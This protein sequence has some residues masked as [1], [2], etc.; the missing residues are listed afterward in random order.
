MI[1]GSHQLA[2]LHQSVTIV[3]SRMERPPCTA[4]ILG[5]G[6]GDVTQD[7]DSPVA[8]DYA[9]LPG[10]AKT[11]AGGH[12][13]QLVCGRLHGVEVVAMSGRF[14]RYEGYSDAEITFPVRL[15]AALGAKRLVVSNAAGGLNPM[16]NTGDVVV[17]QDHIDL[18]RRS[19]GAGVDRTAVTGTADL[20]DR[21]LIA[22]ALRAAR[23]ADFHAQRGVYLA[24]LGPTYETRAEYRMMRSLGA[25]VVGMSTAPEVCV[26]RHLGMRVLALSIVSNVAQPDQPQPTHH[27]EVLAAGRAATSKLQAIVAAVLH[28]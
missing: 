20:Y 11:T 17:I 16:L 21:E 28:E 19:A 2:A 22:G 3:R 18:G 7:F 8:I 1:L 6:L 14:H 9:E 15:L 23:R 13:G 27:E 4:I 5:S 25:D 12:R 24:T 10:F 26:A